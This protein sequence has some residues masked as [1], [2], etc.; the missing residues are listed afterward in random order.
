MSSSSL[1]ST[2]SVISSTAADVLQGDGM[3]TN[4]I[5][6]ARLLGHKS[7]NGRYQSTMQLDKFPVLG[8]QMTHSIDSC[9]YISSYGALFRS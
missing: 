5:T 4:M 6:A 1:V 9:T 2:S 3:T 8:H 7:I